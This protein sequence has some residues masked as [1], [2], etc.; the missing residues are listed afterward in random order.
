MIDQ[1]IQVLTVYYK[2]KKI[3]PNDTKGDKNLQ[4]NFTHSRLSIILCTHKNDFF[5]IKIR[6]FK[7]HK[8]CD[9]DWYT[10]IAPFLIISLNC[11][12]LQKCKNDGSCMDCVTSHN[13]DAILSCD[14]Q[15]SFIDVARGRKE[16]I[17]LLQGGIR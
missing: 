5:F 1:N 3:R 11:L 12:I 9:S 14:I 16:R 2:K 13:G 15:L 10:I 7:V 8:F 4:M 17:Q 6:S